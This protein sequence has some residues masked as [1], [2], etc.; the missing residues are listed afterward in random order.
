[1]IYSYKIIYEMKIMCSSLKG[2]GVATH[3]EKLRTLGPNQRTLNFF[4][5]IWDQVNPL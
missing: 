3:F 5:Q 2:H 1:M 4:F